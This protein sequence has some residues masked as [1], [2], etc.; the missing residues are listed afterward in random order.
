MTRI[1]DPYTSYNTVIKTWKNRK[2]KS[3]PTEEKLDF[4]KMVKLLKEEVDGE[5]YMCFTYVVSVPLC[6]WVKCILVM[7]VMK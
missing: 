1:T 2:K 7:G 6:G 3:Q 4:A 5:P